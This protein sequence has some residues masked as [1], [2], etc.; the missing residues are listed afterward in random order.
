MTFFTCQEMYK[1]TLPESVMHSP[2]KKWVRST[3]VLSESVIYKNTNI[4]A[5]WSVIFPKHDILWV[6]LF[7]LNFQM[8]TPL[9]RHLWYSL[10]MTLWKVSLLMYLYWHFKKRHCWSIYVDTYGSAKGCPKYYLFIDTLNFLHITFQ[11][12]FYKIQNNYSPI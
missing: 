9:K 6:P 4:D 7:P 3:M 5:Y 2:V 10:S 12:I 11:V 8:L 1:M